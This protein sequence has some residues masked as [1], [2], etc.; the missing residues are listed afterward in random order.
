MTNMFPS[1]ITQIWS[2][3]NLS[4]HDLSREIVAGM[5]A[6]QDPQRSPLD[7]PWNH[8]LD[9]YSRACRIAWR[10]AFR[11]TREYGGVPFITIDERRAA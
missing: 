5:R 4:D 3:L 1:E 10:L 2:R 6:A 7:C 11:L 8:S 9:R